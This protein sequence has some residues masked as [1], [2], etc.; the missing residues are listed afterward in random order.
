M[1]SAMTSVFSAGDMNETH[2]MRFKM[3]DSNDNGS[4]SLG[5]VKDMHR[6]YYYYQSADKNSDGALDKSEFSAFEVEVPDYPGS[7]GQ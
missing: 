4:I 3:L 7:T 6:I 2:E 5:E 1:L